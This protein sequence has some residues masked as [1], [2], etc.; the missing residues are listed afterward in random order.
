[1]RRHQRAI[2]PE[3]PGVLDAPQYT[4]PGEPEYVL[5]IPALVHHHGPIREQTS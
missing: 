1:M 5:D 2:H 4:R 3:P